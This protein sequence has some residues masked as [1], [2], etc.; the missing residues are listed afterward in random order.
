MKKKKK[1]TTEG[2]KNREKSRPSFESDN[3]IDRAEGRVRARF[4]CLPVCQRVRRRASGAATLSSSTLKKEMGMERRVASRCVALFHYFYRGLDMYEQKIKFPPTTW[5]RSLKVDRP[6]GN[7]L[8]DVITFPIR[9][10]RCVQSFN[11]KKKIAS[12]DR[13][14]SKAALIASLIEIL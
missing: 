5:L 3:D 12:I 6:R 13:F 1:L 8:L 14:K 9:G 11:K 4:S 10:K 2:A 7:F